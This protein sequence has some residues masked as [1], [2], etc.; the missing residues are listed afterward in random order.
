MAVTN[1]TIKDD[2]DLTD[3]EKLGLSSYE[4]KTYVEMLSLDFTTARE[5]SEISKVPFGR[6]YDVLSKLEVKGLVEKQN[7]RPAKFRAETPKLAI[8]KLINLKE[9]EIE[10]IKNTAPVIEEKL[11]KF[12][13]SSKEESLFWSVAMEEETMAQHEAKLMEA[14]E[15]ILIYMH[16]PLSIPSVSI[17]ESNDFI[18]TIAYL[19]NIKQ[20][21]IK[22]ILG[23]LT[24][25]DVT[26]EFLENLNPIKELLKGVEV[27]YSHIVTNTFDVID[28]EKVIIKISNPVQ[29]NEY[30]AMIFLW[31]KNFAIKMRLKFFEI[32]GNATPIL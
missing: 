7:S 27:R 20:V 1:E 31:Q 16:T 30:L 29:S 22:I 6:M 21:E 32:W 19:I 2:F 25:E 28:N 13:G 18:E 4:A 5:I 15:E 17:P 24:H 23:S 9:K 12:Y 14:E 3:L 10:T 8:N 11:A 26:E